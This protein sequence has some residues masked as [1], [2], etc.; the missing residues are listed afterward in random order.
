MNQIYETEFNLNMTSIVRNETSGPIGGRKGE[1][2]KFVSGRGIESGTFRIQSGIIAT[3]S[4]SPV[5]RFI[6]RHHCSVCLPIRGQDGCWTL[7]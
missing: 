7:N 5:I 1:R 6:K 3:G 2:R 4:K